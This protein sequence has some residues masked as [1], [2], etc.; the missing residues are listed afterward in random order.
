[1][2]TETITLHSIFWN[3][4]AQKHHSPGK[5]Y[6]VERVNNPVLSSIPW[7]NDNT[8]IWR[9]ITIY[10]DNKLFTLGIQKLVKH[11]NR[12]S[13]WYI[14]AD[15]VSPEFD[16]VPQAIQWLSDKIIKGTCGDG[17]GGYHIRI[18]QTPRKHEVW[19]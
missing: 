5:H 1:M 8:T 4:E 10:I 11:K 17:S 19:I 13:G 16:T 3:T 9:Q 14:D 12:D 7:V 2:E 18:N 6:V 15:K